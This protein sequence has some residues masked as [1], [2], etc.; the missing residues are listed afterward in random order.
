MPVFP[1]G[2]GPGLRYLPVL[3]LRGGRG[4]EI[5]R[6]TIGHWVVTIIWGSN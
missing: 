4:S 2:P 3:L 1:M 5:L 6:E